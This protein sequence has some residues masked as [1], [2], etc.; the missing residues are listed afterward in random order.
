MDTKEEIQHYYRGSAVA[1]GYV[2]ERFTS[3]LHRLLH[4]RQVA[5]VRRASDILRPRRILEIAPGPGRVTADVSPA[6]KLVCLE[7][8]EG[9]ITVG[10]ATCDGRAVWVRGD[11]FELPFSRSF[12]LVYSFRFIRH[13]HAE[14]RRKFYAEVRRVLEPGG[15]FVMDA[16]NESVSRPLREAAPNEYPVYD[17]LY[18]REELE[19][20]LRTAGLE[21]RE[22]TPVQ[23]FFHWQHS[24]QVW[25]GP[26]AN[27]LNR[28][29]IRLLERL[30]HNQGL[31]WII[32]SS[33]V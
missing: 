17:K 30:P 31:E 29:V 24:S 15:W 27:W 32:A 18:G 5:A 21:P 9:M 23:K 16:V 7:Y 2:R 28:I 8:N 11:G 3:E 13:F 19:A 22:I 25:L 10:R 12:D 4:E 20:E 14:E 26:R 33:R 1:E 6:G